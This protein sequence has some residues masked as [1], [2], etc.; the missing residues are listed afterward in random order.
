[1]K[2]SQIPFI[3]IIPGYCACGCG[4]KTPIAPRNRPEIGWV[5]GQPV[6]YVVGHNRKHRGGP[7]VPLDMKWC[8]R[9][10]K[11]KPLSDFYKNQ[12]VY[13]GTQGACKACCY[14]THRE[15]IRKHPVRSK[16]YAMKH[17]LKEKYGVGLEAYDRLLEA[18]GGVCAI[19][20]QPETRTYSGFPQLMS[21]DH[22]HLTGEIRGILCSNC[23]GALGLLKE[24]TE[25]MRKAIAYLE[26]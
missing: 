6:K 1:M 7:E 18:Q 10:K 23:N 13:C 5:K 15:Y 2:T 12:A 24:D 4:Q 17:R 3:A 9:S 14:E 16:R 19:C 20:G 8:F 25:I 11:I 21:V 22:N 26:R